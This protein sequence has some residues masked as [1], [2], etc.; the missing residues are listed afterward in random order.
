MVDS[1]LPRMPSQVP[2]LDV[3]GTGETGDREASF[4][5]R[6]VLVVIVEIVTIAGLY[7]FGRYFS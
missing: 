6:Y 7:W 4:T 3:D 1:I 5:R 2:P